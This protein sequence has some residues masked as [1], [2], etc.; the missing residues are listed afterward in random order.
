MAELLV[1]EQRIDSG[2]ANRG[3]GGNEVPAKLWRASGIHL[4]IG[5]KSGKL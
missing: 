3:M 4:V 1:M 2:P 5:F